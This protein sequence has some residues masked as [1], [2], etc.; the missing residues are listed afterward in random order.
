MVRRGRPGQ[1]LLTGLNGPASGDT[2]HHTDERGVFALINCSALR[3]TK[4]KASD[5]A[6]FVAKP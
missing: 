4:S 5:T 3:E 2:T 6:D 1:K